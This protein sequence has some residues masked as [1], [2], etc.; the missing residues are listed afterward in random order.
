MVSVLA[1]NLLR[2]HDEHAMILEEQQN[3][4]TLG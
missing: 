3:T 4:A 2:Q 1:R